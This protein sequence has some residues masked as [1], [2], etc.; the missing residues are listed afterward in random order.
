MGAFDKAEA[1]EDYRNH[2]LEK[3]RASAVAEPTNIPL[4]GTGNLI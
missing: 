4:N 3:Y 2:E 1:C